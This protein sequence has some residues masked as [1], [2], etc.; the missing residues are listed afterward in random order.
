MDTRSK[1]ASSVGIAL[2]FILSPVLPDATLD[3]GDRQHMAWSYS[4]IASEA[5]SDTGGRLLLLGVGK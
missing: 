2:V 1:R 4:G 3:Q 5:A